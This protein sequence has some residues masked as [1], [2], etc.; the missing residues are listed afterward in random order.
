MWRKPKYPKGQTEEGTDVSDHHCHHQKSRASSWCTRQTQ[1]G[2]GQGFDPLKNNIMKYLLHQ[3]DLKP[4]CITE[5]VNNSQNPHNY[6]M[7]HLRTLN[8]FA[9]FQ[10][11]NFNQKPSWVPHCLHHLIM[12]KTNTNRERPGTW[13]LL[14]SITMKLLLHQTDSTSMHHSGQFSQSSQ[15]NH[16]QTLNLLTAF[17]SRF[18]NQNPSWVPQCFRPLWNVQ[19]KYKQEEARDWSSP[20]D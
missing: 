11:R 5:G 13:F 3:T 18:F 20:K 10:S 19:D 9:A 16:L 8:F 12:Y 4:Q 15:I 2:R 6:K 17:Q 7:T 14:K 1:I